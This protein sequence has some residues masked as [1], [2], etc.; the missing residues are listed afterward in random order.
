[1]PVLS[2]SVM[3]TWHETLHYTPTD[4]TDVLSLQAGA[5]GNNQLFG[6]TT[7]ATSI[8]DDGVDSTGCH[9]HTQWQFSAAPSGPAIWYYRDL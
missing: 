7:I 3:T 5:N 9:S 4:P 8:N 2:Q 1:M 6:L